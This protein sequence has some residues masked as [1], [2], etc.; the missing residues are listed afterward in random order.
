MELLEILENYLKIK[1]L[2]GTGF[3]PV[4][5]PNPEWILRILL[6]IDPDNTC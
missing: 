2:P 3:S 6:T 4:T 1:N 5:Y